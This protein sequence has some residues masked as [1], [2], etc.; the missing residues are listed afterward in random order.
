MRYAPRYCLRMRFNCEAQAGH[1]CCKFPLPPAGADPAAAAQERHQ[2][3]PAVRIRP[4]RLPVTKTA[5]EIN[6]DSNGDGSKSSSKKSNFVER[7][8]PPAASQ[9]KPAVAASAAVTLKKKPRICLR[10][11]VNCNVNPAH[12]CCQFQ[13][14]VQEEDV[15]EEEQQEFA[16]KVDASSTTTT[17]TTATTVTTGST[18]VTSSDG[19]S[20]IISSE[21]NG[22]VS[23]VE[24]VSPYDHEKEVLDKP[25]LEQRLQS[26][27][28]Q[29][30]PAECF[31]QT[32][33]CD[34]P[35]EQKKHMCCAY[36]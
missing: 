23:S 25:P 22:W 27:V 6:E 20:T 32:F 3:G 13:D 4:I 36:M 14:D 10:L 8:R 21:T 35:T 16:V 19:F 30:I 24:P 5:A 34:A 1:V 11:V 28:H 29:K 12:R 9:R 17:M 15:Q 18:T 7:K 26:H 31:K 33:D 2:S